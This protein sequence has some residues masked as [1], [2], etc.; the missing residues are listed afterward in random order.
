MQYKHELCKVPPIKGDGRTIQILDSRNFPACKTV[1]AALVT[2]EPGAMR[3]IHSHTNQDE[4][5]YY[6]RDKYYKGRA[7]MT[8][9]MPDSKARTFN[10]S[11]GDVGYV[12]VG[13][14]H[15]VQNIGD[16]PL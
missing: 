1:A 11:P 14:F 13:G 10:Y 2:V 3:K 4:F 8:E 6:I 9:F 5:Q 7:R 16:E 15:Y 12:P